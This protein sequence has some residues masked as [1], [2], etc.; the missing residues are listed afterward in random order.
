MAGISRAMT[1]GGR[2]GPNKGNRVKT[3][4]AILVETGKPLVLAELEIPP[5]K[6]GH[7]LIEIAYSGACGTQVMEAQ[8]LKG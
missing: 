4:A 1:R 6:P 5:L 7:T 3:E 8:G 2:T